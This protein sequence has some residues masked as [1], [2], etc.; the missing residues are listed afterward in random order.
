MIRLSPTSDGTAV[1]DASV[2]D[3]PSISITQP[4][5]TT[6]AASGPA[7]SEFDMSIIEALRR[8]VGDE[9]LKTLLGSLCAE[10]HVAARRAGE[11][12]SAQAWPEL[13]VNAHSI[14]SVAS[15]FGAV[16][17]AHESKRLEVSAIE[18]QVDETQLADFSQCCARVLKELEDSILPHL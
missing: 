10:I 9:V 1:V 14:K 7:V 6:K 13:Q 17:L 3:K 8:E 5:Q 15:S 4:I 2:P 18:G 11:Q 16:V 12:H